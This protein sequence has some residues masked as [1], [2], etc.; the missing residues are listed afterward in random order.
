M[1]IN[2]MIIS[3]VYSVII[4]LFGSLYKLLAQRQTEAENWRFQTKHTNKLISRLFQFN[5]FNFYLP[6]I[7]VSFDSHSGKNFVDLFY[8]MLS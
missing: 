1:Q 3:V 4:I 5:F 8:L 2:G 6:M 7:I